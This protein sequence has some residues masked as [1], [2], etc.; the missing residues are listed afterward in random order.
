MKLQQWFSSKWFGAGTALLGATLI[1]GGCRPVTA[2][3]QTGAPAAAA[4]SGQWSDSRRKR[5]AGGAG[6]AGGAQRR[7]GVRAG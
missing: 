7:S 5:N 4:G 6:G 1:L 2:P 3:L